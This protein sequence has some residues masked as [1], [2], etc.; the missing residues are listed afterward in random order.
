MK[1]PTWMITSDLK[2]SEMLKLFDGKSTV[3]MS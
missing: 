1:K 2:R 3:A